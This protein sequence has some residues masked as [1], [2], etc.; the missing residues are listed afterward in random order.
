V[1]LLEIKKEDP[2]I[3]N[4]LKIPALKEGIVSDSFSK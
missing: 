1:K 4:T 2:E 3:Q